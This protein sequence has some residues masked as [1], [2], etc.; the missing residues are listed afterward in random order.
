MG[1]KPSYIDGRGKEYMGV[2]IPMSVVTQIVKIMEPLGYRTVSEFVNEAVRAHVRN[3]MIDYDRTV[4]DL[5][6]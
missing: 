5:V 4:I 1:K 2:A 3:K 6:K